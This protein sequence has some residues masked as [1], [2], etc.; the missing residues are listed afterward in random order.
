[1]STYGVRSNAESSWNSNYG[2]NMLCSILNSWYCV[3]SSYRRVDVAM[4]SRSTAN[5]VLRQF[6]VDVFAHAR[7]C[8]VVSQCKRGHDVSTYQQSNPETILVDFFPCLLSLN[9]TRSRRMDL[10]E[11]AASDAESAHDSIPS[12]VTS[13]EAEIVVLNGYFVVVHSLCWSDVP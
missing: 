1:M 2:L 9:S 5:R 10:R 8:F 4:T 11:I 3:F 12:S 13:I 7:N 6:C